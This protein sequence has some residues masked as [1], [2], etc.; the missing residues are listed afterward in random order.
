[1]VLLAQG[2]SVVEVTR[3]P[4]WFMATG[5]PPTHHCTEGMGVPRKEQLHCRV[6]FKEQEESSSLVGAVREGGSGVSKHTDSL[7]ASSRTQPFLYL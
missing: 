3:K 4:V 2:P 7:S 5:V 1:M 6:F